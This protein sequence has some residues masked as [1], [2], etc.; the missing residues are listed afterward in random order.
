[1]EIPSVEEDF[2]WADGVFDGMEWWN[3]GELEMMEGFYEGSSK[4]FSVAENDV[5]NLSSSA[6][7]A[8]QDTLQGSSA[9]ESPC[10]K[11]R[12]S[13]KEHSCEYPNCGQS[14]SHRYKLK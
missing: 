5:P 11:N 12:D 1:L 8:D 14:F 2:L 13:E 7:E 3:S 4:S 10:P 6:G 9:R